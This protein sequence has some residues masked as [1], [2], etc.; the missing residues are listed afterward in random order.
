[1][2]KRLFDIV[3]SFAGL[4]ALLPLFVIVALLVRLDSEGPVFF[5]QVRVGKDFKPF[6]IYKFRTMHVGAE[7]GPLITVG[8]DTRV[9][10]LGRHLR[11]Y[12][13]DEIPQLINVLK[14]EM[15]LVGPRPEV[16]QFVR[17]FKSDYER[18]LVLRPGITDPATIRYADEESALSLSEDWREDYTKRILPEKIQ[19]S[20]QYV[21][22]HS[23]MTDL[24]IIFKTLLKPFI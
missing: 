16:E 1:M 7:R 6:K 2:M 14:G 21:N 13:I 5:R 18:L 8:G 23:T 20:L 22:N 17:L 24:K 10:R 3:F 12:K 4:I 19:L 9:T 11:R 15:S